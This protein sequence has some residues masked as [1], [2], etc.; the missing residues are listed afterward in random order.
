MICKRA[1]LSGFVAL[2]GSAIIVGPPVPAQATARTGIV[3][4]TLND[5][6]DLT[7][8]QLLGIT[9]D[10]VIAGYFGSGNPAATH[11]NKGFTVRPP[12]RQGSFTNENFPGSQQTQ[13]IG[14][15]NRGTTVGFWV[16]QAGANF[17]FVRR[18]GE[19]TSVSNPMTTSNPPVN[20]LLGI[21]DHGMAVGFY[22]DAA[23]SSHAY[24]YNTRT[25]QFRAITLPGAVSTQATGINNDNDIAGFM[26]DAA[27]TTRAWRLSDGTPTTLVAPGASQTQ[28]FGINNEGQVVG[29][30]VDT[31]NVTHGFLY[32]HGSFKTIDD[33]LA[34]GATTINGIND[35]GAFVGF[36][37]DAAGNTNGM[38][39]LLSGDR[40]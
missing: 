26:T 7:F 28:A 30:F 4:K 27:G 39:G 14:I 34:A 10:G 9:D 13:V 37:T 5:Q 3:F 17:G 1:L 40:R 15:N 20:Q 33:P 36:Y 19:F 23:G 6:A 32:A 12:Y 18:G 22:N 38:L 24:E 11:P 2:V 29:Q 21:N 31:A 25:G 16:D 8:N 35:E